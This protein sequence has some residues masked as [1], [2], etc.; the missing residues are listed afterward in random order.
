MTSSNVKLRDPTHSW[1]I[2]CREAASGVFSIAHFLKQF[3][4]SA[5]TLGINLN[6]QKFRA[7]PGVGHI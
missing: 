6:G 2:L 1:R 7:A 5:P 4:G 3:S